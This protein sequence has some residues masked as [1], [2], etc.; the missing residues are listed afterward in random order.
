ME[1]T[2][3]E[4]IKDDLV[5]ILKNGR[6]SFT[7]IYSDFRKLKKG[8]VTPHY[9]STI[10][11]TLQ[12]HCSDCKQYQGKDDLFQHDGVSVWSLRE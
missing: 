2:M 1:A 6:K 3:A 8:N 5:T 4:S 7:G 10:R 9:Q 12:R 11:C